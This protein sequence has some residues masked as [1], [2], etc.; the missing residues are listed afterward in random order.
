[1][2]ART[3][4]PL[5]ALDAARSTVISS[6]GLADLPSPASHRLSRERSHGEKEFCP[7]G[8]L[9]R[10][11]PD[12]RSTLRV[13]GEEGRCAP[14]RTRTWNGSGR[15]E[16]RP[17]WHPRPIRNNGNR[18]RWNLSTRA[19]R[20]RRRRTEESAAPPREMSERRSARQSAAREAPAAAGEGRR[21]ARADR[22]A[23]AA[24][25]ASGPTPTPRSW[26]PSAGWRSWS[27]ASARPSPASR[28]GR[29]G[30][31]RCRD[32][33]DDRRHRRVAEDACYPASQMIE[34]PVDLGERSYPITIGHGLTSSLHD[35]LRPL[36]GRRIAV[37]SSRR[38]WGLH[39]RR[40]E[41]SLKRLGTVSRVLI[42]DGERNKTLATLAAVHDGLAG[43]GG[44]PRRPG[45]GL[46]GRDGGRRGG[47][48]GRHLHA[49]G[50][51][52]AGARPRSWPWWT[53]RSEARWA[54][55]TP[56]PR[57]SWARSTSPRRWS[58][59]PRCSRPCP[60]ASCAAAPTRS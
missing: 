19:R 16:T 50:D 34:I 29:G 39:G 17:V 1:M 24:S 33:S 53:A 3:R 20:R 46:R 56:G 44:G 15:I 18:T 4:T 55:T 54:S 25:P 10:N 59:T 9:R 12:A 58:R 41:S 45:G 31:A 21:P 22:G 6:H 36:K 35:L 60:C 13:G 48:R 43:R 42:P 38:I 28:T 51:V 7:D 52:G 47:L 32:G 37:V 23:A 5:S 8:G 57:T 11:L 2:L 26:P 27:G 49:R 30:R 14:T 40:L